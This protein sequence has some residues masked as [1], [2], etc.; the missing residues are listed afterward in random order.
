VKADG[1]VWYRGATIESAD[2]PALP[3]ELVPAGDQL[4][5]WFAV[6]KSDISY[7]EPLPAR[8][9]SEVDLQDVAAMVS[10]ERLHCFGSRSIELEGIYGC[11]ACV[12]H[13]FGEFEPDW[14]MNPNAGEQYLN[15][16]VGPNVLT[17]LRLSLRFPPSIA[18]PSFGSITRLR[19]HF[20]DPAARTCVIALDYFWDDATDSHQVPDVVAHE[21]CRREFVVETYDVTGTDPSFGE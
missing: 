21:L 11:P 4:M 20:D 5:G 2:L 12:S 7:V 3:S 1:Y 17:T 6:G 10:G 9:P 18:A 16:H 13:I 19:G 15:V 14:L 8:C